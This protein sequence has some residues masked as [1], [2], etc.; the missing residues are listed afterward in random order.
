M[1]NMA[2]VIII[3]LFNDIVFFLT[4][5]VFL[6]SFL[7]SRFTAKIQESL[8]IGRGVVLMNDS[9]SARL[10]YGYWGSDCG[11]V[12]SAGYWVLAWKV[13]LLWG[14]PYLVRRYGA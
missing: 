7:I 4:L 10:A 11:M 6:S 3:Q 8:V 13:T 14:M 1:N 2:S 12:V 9:L 5:V